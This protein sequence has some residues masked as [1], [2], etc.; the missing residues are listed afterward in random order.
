MRL[1]T[2]LE[3]LETKFNPS[4]RCSG[5][6]FVNIPPD[7]ES[8]ERAIAD[9]IERHNAKYPNQYGGYIVLPHYAN[10]DEWEQTA[11]AQQA[12]LMAECARD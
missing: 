7:A 6:L 4:T 1:K 2:R 10:A 3:K 11:M 8:R 12:A 9:A 5:V